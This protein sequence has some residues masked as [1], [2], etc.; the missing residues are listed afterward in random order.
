MAAPEVPEWPQL[1]PISPPIDELPENPTQAQVLKVLIT[2]LLAFG[3]LWPRIVQALLYLKAAVDRIEKLPP[4]RRAEDTG[5]YIVETSRRVGES[6]KSKDQQIE[7]DPKTKLTP[8]IVG[9]IARAEV[10]EALAEERRSNHE[11]LLEAAAAAAKAKESAEAAAAEEKR[12]DDIETAKT[13]A[14][15]K[16]ERNRLIL[17]GVVVGVLMLFLTSLYVFTLGRLTERQANAAAA[18]TAVPMLP[19]FLPL[20]SAIAAE[21]PSVPPMALARV[22]GASS[23]AWSSDLAEPEPS[24]TLTRLSRPATDD[25]TSKV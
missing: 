9:D 12:L 20:P 8:D 21:P 22:A 5:S 25:S 3:H 10:K 4:M 19:V 23:R 24:I 7:D 18:A 6:A 16:R 17:V 15:E 13:L 14:K 2:T 11:K 1:D